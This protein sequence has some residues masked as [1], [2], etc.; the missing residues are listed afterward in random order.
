M[1]L[2]FNVNASLPGLL[3]QFMRRRKWGCF[4][5]LMPNR[6][7]R[8]KR[9]D[10]IESIA[11]DKSEGDELHHMYLTM[12]KGGKQHVVFEHDDEETMYLCLTLLQAALLRLERSAK[13]FDI[14]W[15]QL[16]MMWIVSTSN[17]DSSHPHLMRW[18]QLIRSNNSRWFLWRASFRHRNLALYVL[19]LYV[20]IPLSLWRVATTVVECL[21]G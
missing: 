10:D 9:V 4:V 14:D 18:V 7:I 11:V 1:A 15:A 21:N 8:I 3:P 2:N 16:A 17:S 13:P 12:R 20:V 19:L 6:T 5:T